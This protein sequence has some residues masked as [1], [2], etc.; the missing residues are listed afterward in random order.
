[1]LFNSSIQEHCLS[2][3]H[4]R[5]FFFFFFSVLAT[6]QCMGSDLS[7]SCVLSQGSDLS[8]SCVLYTAAVATPDPLTTPP[9]NCQARDQTCLLALQRH[10]RSCYATAGRPVVKFL[11]RKKETCNSFMHIPDPHPYNFQVLCYCQ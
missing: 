9:S 8:L 4:R 7:L 1:M 10:C 6:L 2:V 11:S 3:K 5:N